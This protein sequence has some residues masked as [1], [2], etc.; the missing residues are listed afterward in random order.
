MK[1][2]HRASGKDLLF[3]SKMLILKNKFKYGII[4]SFKNK[5]KKFLFSS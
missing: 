1:L 3:S 5:D 4:A 2:A